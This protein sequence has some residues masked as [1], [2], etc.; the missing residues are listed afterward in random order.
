M[1][2]DK[3]IGEK[4]LEFE[5]R[6]GWAAYDE[7]LFRFVNKEIDGTAQPFFTVVATGTSHEP[8]DAD[9]EKIFPSRAGDWC[10]DYLNTV[11]YTDRC[12]KEFIFSIKKQSWYANTLVAIVAD[13]GHACPLHAEPNSEKKH[14]IPLLFL[15]G[16]VLDKVKG[17]T[18]TRVF[19]GYG[20]F[21]VRIK[22]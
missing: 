10:N 19:S 16:A 3:L 1:G 14:H 9:V 12:L 11:H 8:F 6:T 2:F 17:T 5:K 20:S 18:W 7:E 13:H 4:D 21:I 22:T 15:G